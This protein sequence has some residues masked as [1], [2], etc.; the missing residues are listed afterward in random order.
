MSWHSAPD[1]SSPESHG[2]TLNSVGE[3]ERQTCVSYQDDLIVLW[4]FQTSPA[5]TLALPAGL[6]LIIY[7]IKRDRGKK[8]KKNHTIALSFS[9]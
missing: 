6:V 5:Y 9:F 7:F 2:S 8:K 3:R 1:V 4:L